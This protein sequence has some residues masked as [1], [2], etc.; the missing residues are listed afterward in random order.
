MISQVEGINLWEGFLGAA[1]RI[2]TRTLG[3]ERVESLPASVRLTSMK[4]MDEARKGDGQRQ[5][6]RWRCADFF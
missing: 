5:E 2:R 1:F 4:A 6:G 3:V